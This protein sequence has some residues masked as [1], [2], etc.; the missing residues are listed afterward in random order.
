MCQEALDAFAAHGTTPGVLYVHAMDEAEASGY[1]GI[2]LPEGWDKV[3][4]KEYQ[5]GQFRWWLDTYPGRDWYGW[6]ADDNR[7]ATQDFDLKMAAKAVPWGFVCCNG[8]K[9]KAWPSS[10]PSALMWG[11][12][13]V[14]TVGWIAPPRVF[15]ATIDEHW[16]NLSRRAG[17]DQ[18]CGDVLIEHLHWNNGGRNK[19]A[20][21]IAPRGKWNADFGLLQ[22]FLS[23]E[24]NNCSDRIKEAMA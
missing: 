2:R 19:D 18:Y 15:H 24:I 9:G 5:A 7:P 4:G 13:L 6:I 12:E 23:G 10:L 20:T 1:E 22:T 17:I 11:G 14:R 3:T 16:K 8:G 21:D